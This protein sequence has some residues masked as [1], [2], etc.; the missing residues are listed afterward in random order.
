MRRCFDLARLGQAYTRQNPPVGAVVLHRNQ[1]VGEGFHQ[2]YG[3]SH[4]E[5]NA[6]KDVDSKLSGALDTVLYVSLEPCSHYGK[7]PPC[8]NLII[9]RKIPKVMVAVRDPNPEV[10]GRGIQK[11]KRHNVAVIEG[12]NTE[13]AKQ[14][15]RPFSIIQKKQRPYIILKWAQS[16]DGYIGKENQQIKISNAISDRLVHKWRYESDIILIGTKTAI[17]DRPRLSNRLWYGKSPV[18]AIIDRTGKV[19]LDHPI[20]EDSNQTIVYTA[21]A[22][23]THIFNAV[24]IDFTTNI[25]PQILKHLFQT[26]AETLFVEGGSKT[27]KS[28]LDLGAWDEC[29]IIES[30]KILGT[31]IVGPSKPS[32]LK[33]V[34]TL[35]G[36]RILCYHNPSIY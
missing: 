9:E 26:G 28:F 17:I 29:R 19:G 16:L 3:D 10:N 21:L 32:G 22:Q 36:D 2:R 25:I 12:L 4:A 35:S 23:N 7:T 6:L 15:I 20:F 13:K 14:I 8:S 11:L 24:V 33:N 27:L 31:G 30:P 34:A 5:V 1:V 18:K